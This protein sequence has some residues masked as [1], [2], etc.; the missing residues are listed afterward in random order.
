VRLRLP[1]HRRQ[2]HLRSTYVRQIKS[3]KIFLIHSISNPPSPP[4]HK[5]IYPPTIHTP[6]RTKFKCI[7]RPET[8]ITDYRPGRFG[9]VVLL[10]LQT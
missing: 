2:L 9:L 3:K 8:A 1:H 6:A 5:L 10:L 7:F 4:L